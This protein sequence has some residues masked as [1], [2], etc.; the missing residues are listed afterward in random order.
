[1]SR[2]TTAAIFFA[3]VLTGV[4]ASAQDAST[5]AGRW[6]LNRTLS[7]FPPDVG[8]GADLMAGAGRD[9]S[10][11]TALSPSSLSRRESVD[12]ARRL[13]Q[14]TDE[15]RTPSAHLTISD[16]PD[17][18]TIKDDAGH[19]RVFHPTG[20]EE[21]IQLDE[22]PVVAIARREAG[23]LIVTY[24][25]EQ[26]RQMRYTYF[27]A[28][29]APR[30][31]VVDVQF[32]ERGGKGSVRRVYEPSRPGEPVAAAPAAPPA[33]ATKPSPFEPYTGRG[34]TGA[35]PAAPPAAQERYELPTMP[36]RPGDEFKGLTGLSVVVEDLGSEAATCG[37]KQ[38]TIEAA[39]AKGLS[40]A[41]L[42]VLRNSDQDTY[43]YVNINTSK[44]S[45]GF[46]VSR[47]DVI[48]YTHATARM[49]YGSTP[50]Q[51]QVSLL[52]DGGMAG[53]DAAANGQAVL[54]GV[55]Q[56]VEQF[57]ARIRDANK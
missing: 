16:T 35:A 21:V 13:Q 3:L 28:A 55:R 1:M 23:R 10:G 52:R 18:V 56:A 40:D 54:R 37:L 36:Q 25:V 43:L 38:A 7:Q 11:D 45:T 8:F 24:Q 53:G 4:T 2:I 17:A 39:A 27:C 49:P 33:P 51:V 44:V 31:L 14:L 46:C 15:V 30:Q 57:A 29:T 22:V 32:I 41:G 47:Y 42:K 12:D 48:V 9:A 26:N 50:V 20:R 5:L 34:Q 19:S 6:T